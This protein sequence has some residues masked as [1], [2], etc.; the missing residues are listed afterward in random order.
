MGKG[1]CG[2]V[3]KC[4][5]KITGGKRAVKILVKEKMTERDFVRFEHELEMMQDLDHPNILKVFELYEDAKRIYLVTEL[6]T[7][8][9]LYDELIYKE[10]FGED[11]VCRI[12]T[13]ILEAVSFCHRRG[14]AHR[15]IK[16]EN[17]LL[18]SK[19]RY[20]TRLV[21][22]GSSWRIERGKKFAHMVGT[23][24][25]IAPEVLLN[26]YDQ[27]CDMWSIGVIAYM[28]LT[29]R[30][31]FDGKDDREIIRN[32]RQGKY[33]MT[34][35]DFKRKSHACKDFV[36]QLLS[37]D[38]A[39][40]LTATEALKHP[41]VREY[42]QR[43]K[44]EN[45]SKHLIE[46][47]RNLENFNTGPKLQAAVINFV[48]KHLTDKKELTMITRQF[49][50]LDADD[51]GI[52]TKDELVMGYVSIGYD[53]D[54]AVRVVDSIY[55]NVDVDGSGE[56]EHSEWLIAVIDKQKL[57]TEERMRTIFSLFDR[58]G[59]GT[60]DSNE[61]KDLLSQGQ[62]IEHD[63]WAQVIDEVDEN[64]DGVVNFEEFC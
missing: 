35:K 47:L 64:G 41:W 62:E 54:E 14:I 22:F 46:C 40:R 55:G 56:I 6:C 49:K 17:V 57:L 15:D 51:D 24:Y 29:G 38:P 37:Y 58:D 28:L 52:L 60:I 50:N 59:G 63:V 61:I 42:R 48:V 33:D 1:R 12:V 23:P 8:G 5:H 53:R 30:P 34:L 18:D 19:R 25:Y 45:L 20:N 39:K 3:R 2:E 16:L 9:E 31:P 11:D 27:Q 21:D 36:R 4:R 13:Q 10:K 32:V 44:N 43:V 7:G 26:D